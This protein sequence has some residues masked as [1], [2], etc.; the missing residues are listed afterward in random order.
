MNRDSS[1]LLG[2]GRAID[3]PGSEDDHVDEQMLGE[4]MTLLEDE[5]PDALFR[6]CDLFRKGV[7]ERIAEIDGALAEGRLDVVARAAHSL[8]G[9]AGAFGARRLHRMGERLEALCSQNDVNG[10]AAIA[11]GLPGEFEVFSTIL[12]ARLAGLSPPAP[13]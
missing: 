6:A 11:R 13:L 2:G 5:A 9:S 7:S 1:E 3:P 8:R 10:A 12:N 4:I